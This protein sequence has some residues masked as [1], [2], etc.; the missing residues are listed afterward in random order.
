MVDELLDFE[1]AA[2]YALTGRQRQVVCLYCIHGL[3]AKET[4]RLLRL[5]NHSTVIRALESARKRLVTQIMPVATRNDDL[6]HM[7]CDSRL[8]RWLYGVGTGVISPFA[9]MDDLTLAELQQWL[10]DNDDWKMRDW[11]QRRASGWTYSEPDD[12][13]AHIYLDKTYR[14][15]YGREYVYTAEDQMQRLKS[16]NRLLLFSEIGDEAA[17]KK[18]S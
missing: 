15:R 6:K 16:K 13:D 7:V 8:G 12:D 14:T 11:L 2:R 10:A 3:K 18:I 17:L 5:K 1:R 4:A 9:I